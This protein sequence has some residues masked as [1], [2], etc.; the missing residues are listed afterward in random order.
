MKFKGEPGLSVST[1]AQINH[2]KRRV[3]IGTFDE[4]GIMDVTDEQMIP[5]MLDNY[6]K[7]EDI[8]DGEMQEEKVNSMYV[9]KKCGEELESKIMLMNHCKEKHPKEGK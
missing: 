2:K 5:K 6:E 8:D 4:N 7:V 1:I 3:E 9:C